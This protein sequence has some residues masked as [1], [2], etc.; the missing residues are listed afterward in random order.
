MKE[1]AKVE[2]S[3]RHFQPLVNLRRKVNY[4]VIAFCIG[5]LSKLFEL[6]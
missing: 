1:W 5:T 4:Y 3:M 2:A 6:N